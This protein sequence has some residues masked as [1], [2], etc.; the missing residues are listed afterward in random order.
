[1]Y[2]IS[3]IFENKNYPD[4]IVGHPIF[5]DITSYNKIFPKKGL[6][7]CSAPLTTLL[8][9]EHVR[10]LIDDIF[11]TREGVL[12]AINKLD[13]KSAEF[14]GPIKMFFTNF[15]SPDYLD[16]KEGNKI[17]IM[18]PEDL[19]DDRT[20]KV[21]FK[22]GS[23]LFA[24]MEKV[25]EFKVG[26]PN[27]FYY[28]SF[29]DFSRL[30]I[31]LSSAEINFSADPWDIATMSMRGI[32]TCQSWNGEYRQSVIGSMLDPYVGIVYLSSKGKPTDYGT[33]MLFRS[34][35]RFAVENKE[36]YKNK[37]PVLI[38]DCVYPELFDEVLDLFANF[39]EE[40]S[41]LKVLYA[42]R[43]ENDIRDCQYFLPRSKIKETFKFYSEESKY[44]SPINPDDSI[45]SYQNV[46][47]V[48]KPLDISRT[49]V[50]LAKERIKRTFLNTLI[51]NTST[52]GIELSRFPSTKVNTLLAFKNQNLIFKDHIKTAIRTFANKLVKEIDLD[53][54]LD[55][56]SYRVKLYLAYFHKRNYLLE[57]MAS[58]V[59]QWNGSLSLRK[60]AALTKKDFVLIM[61]QAMQ[62]ADQSLK[63]ELKAVF[64]SR[65]G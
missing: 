53:D 12:K 61:R 29:K 36:K 5:K 1:M 2:S 65:R 35:V 43:F 28:D 52:A 14:I 27:I 6:P 15:T 60:S 62:Q 33:K 32:S 7:D 41:G 24:F 48:D 25:I 17:S 9:I 40:K 13:D 37:Q 10:D 4:W 59:L 45:R 54:N 56:G 3:S 11:S 38:L 50:K 64:A 57:A 34:T 30:N 55:E 49:D 44:A 20:N 18:L 22:K 42:P 8:A 16:V 63:A 47:I 23:S 21:V 51:D 46:T 26:I 58:H 19:I 31:P 39:L